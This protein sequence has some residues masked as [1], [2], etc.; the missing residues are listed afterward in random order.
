MEEVCF[1]VQEGE[2]HEYLH[3]KPSLFS[4]LKRNLILT[5]IRWGGTRFIFLELFLKT[6]LHLFC[7]C[8]SCGEIWMELYVLLHVLLEWGPRTTCCTHSTM[9]KGF[10]PAEKYTEGV[11]FTPCFVVTEQLH[12]S[13]GAAGTD[14][15]ARLHDRSLILQ[16][17]LLLDPDLSP[18]F[19]PVHPFIYQAPM[20][21]TYYC[22]LNAGKY[23]LTGRSA[24]ADWAADWKP[25]PD[26]QPVCRIK[27]WKPNAPVNSCN[28][29]SMQ[30]KQN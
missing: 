20:W 22:S 27:T 12:L 6:N 4:V 10:C 24:P 11:Y 2:E 17:Q 23:P 7:P 15:P 16:M 8:A 18:P 29:I 26:S 25:L 3:R 28:I 19:P 5:R 13:G 21:L 14:H 1:S 30:F 9:C